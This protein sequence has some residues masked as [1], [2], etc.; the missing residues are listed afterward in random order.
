[1][2][3]TEIIFQLRERR[4]RLMWLESAQT[5]YEAKELVMRERFYVD[6]LL[7]YREKHGGLVGVTE[8]TDAATINRK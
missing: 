4:K 8:I 3:N 7:N 1:M 5:K 2:L 6:T